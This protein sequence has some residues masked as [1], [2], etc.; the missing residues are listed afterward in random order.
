MHEKDNTTEKC[1][2]EY[3]DKYMEK[4]FYFCLKKTGRQ[5][6]A[7]DLTAE[8]SLCVIAE[9][10]RGV[11]PE[12]F[13]AWVWRIA[14]NRYSRWADEKRKRT[15]ALSGADIED[16]EIAGEMTLENEYAKKEDL[17][18]LRREL[19]FIASDYRNVI[20]AYYIEDK[21]VR[22]IAAALN[23]KAETVK[24]RL[25]R[26]RKILK[27]GMDM[28]REFGERSYRPE[29]IRFVNNCSSFGAWGQPWSILSHL[30]YKNI[31][32]ACYG[33][34]MT[35]EEISVE[36][37]IAL[38]YMEDELAFLVRETFLIKAGERFETAFPIIS[39]KAQTRIHQKNENVAEAVT[40]LFE[41]LIDGF[42]ETCKRCEFDYYGNWQSWE[43]AKWTL[44]MLAVDSLLADV[45]RKSRKYEYTDRPYNGK[46][47][48]VGYQQ[49][50]YNPLPFVGLD[51][52]L[53]REDQPDICFHQYKFQHGDI[54]FKTPEHLTYDEGAA[55]KLVAEGKWDKC[56]EYL[57]ERL[58]NFGYIKKAENNYIPNLVVFDGYDT[59]KYWQSFNETERKGISETANKIRVLLADACAYANQIIKEDLPPLFRDNENM[60]HV[61]CCNSRF[62]RE[63]VFE[64][65]LR[66]GWLKYDQN[67]SVSVGACLYI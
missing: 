55:L 13:P 39:R 33:S 34:P 26:V 56:E 5:Q 18:L 15:D 21:S 20:V 59:D 63:Y 10:R 27:E 38:P 46:W 16:F 37:G 66:D 48:I 22:D 45:S 52:C 8:I 7:E 62:G 1:I 61:A 4:I 43:D 44:L 54:Q 50:D 58:V 14:R 41:E 6:E 32:L 3:S 49:T 64:Q 42:N 35:A 65:T 51:G 36:L 53:G 40:K 57:L 28:A 23:L 47:D 11:I 19:A 67:T 31:F 9:L 17:S 30:L 12:K 2:A 24:K 60:R 25:Q 29:E